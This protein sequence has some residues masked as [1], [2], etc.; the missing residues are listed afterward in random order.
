MVKS[1][2][3]LVIF[4]KSKVGITLRGGKKKQNKK[5]PKEAAVAERNNTCAIILRLKVHISFLS[6]AKRSEALN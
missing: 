6:D 4:Y 5:K 1:L 2:P 3:V